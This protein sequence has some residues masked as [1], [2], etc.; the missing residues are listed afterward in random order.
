MKNFIRK[1]VN[2]T[3]HLLRTNLKRIGVKGVVLVV[4]TNNTTMPI[5]GL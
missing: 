2:I 5:K 4:K 1:G 3:V